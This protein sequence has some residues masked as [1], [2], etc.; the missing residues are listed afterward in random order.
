ME[1]Q[2]TNR[3]GFG[4]DTG[5]LIIL[6][7]IAAVSIFTI[8]SAE[9]ALPEHLQAIDFA[10]KQL[11]WYIVGA[12]VIGFTMIIDFDRFRNFA[13][14]LYGL[15]I[16]LLLGLE[17]NFPPSL[18][19]TIK[20]ATAWYTLPGLGNFQPSEVMK[21]FLV[22]LL[23]K[24]I[25]EHHET[26]PDHTAHDDLALLG[27]IFGISLPPLLLIAKQPDL[28][29]TMVICAMIATMILIS[30]IR[31]RYIGYLVGAT[32]SAGAF[33]VGLYFFKREWFP[34]QDYQLDRFYGWLQPFEYDTQGYQLRTAMLATGSGGLFG[35]G[36]AEGNVYF[37]EPHTDFIFTVVAEEFGFIGAV[38]VIS[39]Y[40][41]LIYRMI[42]IA[43]DS[44]DTYGSYLCAGITG[45]L[46]FQIFQNIGMTI[47]V[48][49]IT[50]ITLPLM[51]YGGSALATY[52]LSIGIV[53]NV[54]SRTKKF[55]FD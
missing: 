23:A 21:I 9:Q 29:N 19:Q 14:Y 36:Y 54:R 41:L 4:L 15:G 51:S 50:G 24:V 2:E 13:W 44:N 10:K 33:L 22:I 52:M 25:F 47:G 31:W 53:L 43:V 39:L 8:S 34:L 6:F 40:F 46:T 17:F 48:L 3:K 27:K 55:M 30:G 42:Q 7:L 12:I 11:V 20:G 18:V 1:T 38:F 5:L 32:V 28:G 37:P 49:P 35:K 45:M 16:I 26:H